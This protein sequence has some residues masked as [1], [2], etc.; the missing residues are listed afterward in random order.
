[1]AGFLGG[2]LHVAHSGTDVLG[3][4]IAAVERAHCPAKG[5]EQRIPVKRNLGRAENRLRPRRQ[6]RKGILV[7]HALGKPEGI[8]NNRFLVRV[9]PEATTARRPARVRWSGWR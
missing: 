6:A 7:A 8:G 4:D 9:V 5:A 3:G 1:M 2:D